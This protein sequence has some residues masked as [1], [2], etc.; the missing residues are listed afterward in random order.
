M[1]IP[2]FSFIHTYRVATPTILSACSTPQFPHAEVPF[3]SF[4][5]T[6]IVWPHPQSYL[7]AARLSSRMLKYRFSKDVS[8]RDLHRGV[9]FRRP[10]RWVPA[11]L[12]Q[13]RRE[14]RIAWS[15]RYR[16]RACVCVCFFFFFFKY[17]RFWAHRVTST[18]E[19]MRPVFPTP[20]PRQY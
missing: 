19:T 8:H 10:P 6:R 16:V 11:F 20:L 13:S 2:L 12:K 15:P 1:E 14:S 18:H 5:H 3:L 9:L 17:S 4:I 7:H